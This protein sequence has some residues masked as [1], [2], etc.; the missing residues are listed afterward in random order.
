MKAE[1]KP[2]EPATDNAGEGNTE[3]FL[4]LKS[5]YRVQKDLS[6]FYF[7][8]KMN[9]IYL[10]SLIMI[11]S[12]SFNL[13]T[14]IS[15]Y[16]D[17]EKN[18]IDSSEFKTETIEVDALKGIERYT[19]V[20]FENIERSE[21]EKKYSVQ[22]IPMFL[23]G[24][25]GINSYSESGANVG[26]SYLTL[27]GFDQRR[28]S[29][30]INGIPQNDPEDHQVYWVDISDLAASVESIQIQRGVGTALYGSS[31][32]GGVINIET[33]DFF[34][35][36]F[37]NLTGGFGDFNTRKYS[38]E[39][40]SGNV[41]NGFGFY[42]KFTKINTDGYR[43]LSWSDHFSYFLSAGKITGKNSVLKLNLFGSPVRNHLAYL[44]VDKAALDGKISGDQEKD[45]RINYLTYP[46]ETD[47][48][49]QP[50]YEI[51]FNIQPSKNLYVS[52]TISYI[53]GDGYFNT[54]FP[55]DYGYD[56]SYFR[57][58]PFFVSD[59]TTF[60]S[61]YYRRNADGT[62]Y[63]E[64]GKGYEIVRSD[65][66]TKLTVNNNTYGW[67]PKVQISHNK[68]K[69]KA[70]L[71][72]EV[73]FHNSEHFGEVTFGEA[74]P[75]GTEPNHLYYFYNGGKKTFS[76]YANEI[77]SFTKKLNAML[78]LQYIH[79]RYE[80][81]N[82]RFKPYN[83]SVSY[84]FFTPR[85]GV[86]YNFSDRFSGYVNYSF[87]KREPRLKDI[88]DAEDPDSRPNFRILDPAKG[89]YEDPLIKPEEMNDLEIGF[90][91]NSDIL[92]AGLNFYNMDFKNE[93]VNN[94]QLDN[95]GQ[96]IVGNAGRSVHRGVEID[97]VHTS[98]TS[99]YMKGFTLSGNL[100]LSD[101]YFKEY[102]EI[103]GADSTGNII[104][105]NDY[106]GNKI[107]LTPDV[108]G[109]LSVEFYPL[110]GTGAYLS[111]MHIG[112][113]YLDNSENERKDTDVR[114]QPGYIDK[115]IEPYTVINAGISLDIISLT[116]SKGLKKMFSTIQMDMKVN[117]VFNLKY[118]M[119]GNVSFGTP[120]WIPAAERNIYAEIKVGF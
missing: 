6:V 87:A 12:V 72:G 64:Q 27:R 120:Y 116:E 86:N 89:I 60:N 48:Y 47:N 32:I 52:N 34:K 98:F 42:G 20:T 113:Q 46:D 30:L 21:I 35:R 115:V 88:Y 2:A 84:D 33:I 109:N 71:G 85:A 13:Q 105:G 43:D 74:L 41:S 108:I 100:S 49:F 51:V 9:K 5:F 36:K 4:T 96:P 3:K 7:N 68:D 17:T 75:Q 80:L 19:P 14:A 1:S 61:S 11:A 10:Y 18:G 38:F 50:H 83:F 59:T 117:N 22:D 16:K 81:S 8:K 70:V 29:I 91:Y 55:T 26:Y 54:S 28:L 67:F 79:H 31:A 62:F 65:M 63:F 114:S 66:I 106:S 53:R 69:G 92:K 90:G 73:R 56:Y 45:R 39:Y 101:N 93:I 110:R 24:Y 97:F 118:E 111:L 94:G 112:K 82:D 104:Y 107:I 23:N 15:Q 58:N 99:N 95:V 57:L 25:T 77:Y 119:S 103:T 78:G 37:L 76:V 40:S 44:G 102:R